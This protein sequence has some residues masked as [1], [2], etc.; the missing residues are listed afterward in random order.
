MSKDP[1]A[2]AL[3]TTFIEDVD[4]DQIQ[5]VKEDEEEDEFA[6]V[7]IQVDSSLVSVSAE[8][9]N[10]DNAES[11][12]V[13]KKLKTVAETAQQFF[14]IV[15]REF[16]QAPTAKMAESVGKVLESQISALNKL[17]DMDEN[18]KKRLAKDKPQQ[19]SM[20]ASGDIN[21]TNNTIVTNREDLLKVIKENAAKKDI[22]DIKKVE[23]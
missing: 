4:L 12:Y 10:Y 8:P 15:A 20:S 13:R 11:L 9:E 18:R 17:A 14:G 23:E 3:G 1:I 16:Q 6:I 2:D 5:D 21:V 22:V 7:P 19:P